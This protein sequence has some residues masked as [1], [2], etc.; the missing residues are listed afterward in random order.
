MNR[1]TDDT[2]ALTAFLLGREWL[3]ADELRH[4][5]ARLG[6]GMPSSQWIAGRLTAMCKESAPRFERRPILG[7]TNLREYRVTG[8]AKTGLRNEWPGFHG[9]SR[10]LSSPKPEGLR[11]QGEVG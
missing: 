9:P 1:P 8:W 3:A 11:Q 6:F 2:I 10:P 7:F 5:L 4:G